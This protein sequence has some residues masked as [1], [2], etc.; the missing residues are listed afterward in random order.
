MRRAGREA[1]RVPLRH[2][3]AGE[4]RVRTFS[5]DSRPALRA[6]ACGGRPRAGSDATV[7]GVPASPSRRGRTETVGSMPHGP[8]LGRGSSGAGVGNVS[9]A[10][11]AGSGGVAE[12]RGLPRKG[13]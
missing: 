1:C 11:Y 7:T 6:A 2:V 8:T 12:L 10:G 4:V 5:T 13:R 9:G 3:R